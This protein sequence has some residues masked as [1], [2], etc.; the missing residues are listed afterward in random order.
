[1]NSSP[2]RNCIYNIKNEL[3]EFVEINEFSVYCINPLYRNDWFFNNDII[4]FINNG[5]LNHLEIDGEVL[6]FKC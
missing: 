5:V 3:P 4:N 2:L 6:A 1:M